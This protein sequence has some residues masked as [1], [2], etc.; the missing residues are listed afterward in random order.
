MSRSR[1]RAPVVAPPTTISW[2]NLGSSSY[3][4]FLVHRTGSGSVVVDLVEWQ[5]ETSATQLSYTFG[6]TALYPHTTG[7]TPFPSGET[8]M[9]AVVGFDS[10][11]WANVTSK[12]HGP[13]AYATDVGPVFGP[14]APRWFKTM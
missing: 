5:V 2:N 11:G 3:V 10:T 8:Y 14:Y 4:L 6:G 12:R 9:I 1:A 7:T 13:S